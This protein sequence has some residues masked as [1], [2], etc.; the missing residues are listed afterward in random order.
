MEPSCF[1]VLFLPQQNQIPRPPALQHPFQNNP[2]PRQKAFWTSS[3]VQHLIAIPEGSWTGFP[4]FPGAAWGRM[5][6]GLRHRPLATRCGQLVLLE[7]LS[8]AWFVSAWELWLGSQMEILHALRNLLAFW[9]PHIFP[10]SSAL[11]PG[12]S[13]SSQ[14]KVL[15]YDREV[16]QGRPGW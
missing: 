12:F 16:S 8:G 13:S 7:G 11:A 2:L 1:S 10:V 4:N 3:L 14:R 6:G 15:P 9:K 5:A